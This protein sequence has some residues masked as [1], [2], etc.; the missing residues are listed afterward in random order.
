MFG[1][2]GSTE[3]LLILFIMLIW[4]WPFWK[5]FQK[6][7]YPGWYFFVVFIPVVN[8]IALFYFAFA[9]WPVHK[10]LREAGVEF[11]LKKNQ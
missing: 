2:I 3:L 8:L 6:A 5:I 9:E 10:A 11:P 7:G 1:P 4:V